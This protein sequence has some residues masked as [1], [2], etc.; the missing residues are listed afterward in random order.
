MFNGT[1]DRLMPYDGGDLSLRRGRVLPATATAELFSRVNGCTQAPTITAEPDTVAD[2]TRIRRSTYTGCRGTR[3]VVLV[4]IEG[5]GHTWPGGPPVSPRVGRV[6]RDMD[7]NRTMLDFFQRHP[8]PLSR[9][10]CR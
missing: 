9:K 8:L 7:A 1:L 2:G 6:S 3:A 5:G 4:T 10:P